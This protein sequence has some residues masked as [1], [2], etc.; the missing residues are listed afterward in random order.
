MVGTRTPPLTGIRQIFEPYHTRF[1]QALCV[2]HDVRLGDRHEIRCPKESAHLDLV[3]DSLLGH[4]PLFAG[5]H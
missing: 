4:M 5:E 3:L 1:A 2:C